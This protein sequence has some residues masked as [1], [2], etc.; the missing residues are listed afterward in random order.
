[1]SDRKTGYFLLKAENNRAVTNN[2]IFAHA[3]EKINILLS[4]WSIFLSFYGFNPN[5]QGFVTSNLLSINWASI[6][7]REFS[8]NAMYS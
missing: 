2:V 5:V 4:V 3:H 7:S 6:E 8:R 1:M